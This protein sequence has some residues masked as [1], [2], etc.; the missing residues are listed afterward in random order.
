MQR[1]NV[2]SNCI[3]PFAWSRMIG[4]IPAE[5]TPEQIARVEQLKQ[6][7]PE[8][9]AP[10]AVY[11]ASDAAEGVTGQMFARPQERDLPVQPAAPDP[12]HAPKLD[13]GRSSPS[14]A[15]PRRSRRSSAQATYY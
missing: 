10:L 12:L 1:F 3:A 11:L 4:T 9:I 14:S 8:K 6:M 2:R 5:T 15:P 13:P 7:T